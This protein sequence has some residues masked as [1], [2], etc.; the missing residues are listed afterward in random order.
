MKANK[1]IVIH[2]KTNEGD[3]IFIPYYTWSNRGEGKMKVFFEK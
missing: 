1:F 2:E 3:C